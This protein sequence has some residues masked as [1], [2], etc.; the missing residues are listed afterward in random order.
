MSAQ[1]AAQSGLLS[2]LSYSRPHST[3]FRIWARVTISEDGYLETLYNS[4]T[5][6]K[7]EKFIRH[8]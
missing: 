5:G 6:Q 3:Q 8:N 2:L 1:R 7:N 4:L